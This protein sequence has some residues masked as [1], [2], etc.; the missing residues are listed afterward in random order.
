LLIS[1]AVAAVA[2][3]VVLYLFDPTASSFYPPCLFRS[4]TGL[5]CPGC[6]ITRAAHHLLHGRLAEAF[7][8]NA[9]AVVF[10]PLLLAGAVAETRTVIRGAPAPRF[11]QK[12]WIAWTALALL[13][14]WGVLR[15]L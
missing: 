7:H 3:L 2:G 12:P 10:G 6:G 8:Y 9:M 15:N 11:V 5:L 4:L 14:G 1:G 13:V